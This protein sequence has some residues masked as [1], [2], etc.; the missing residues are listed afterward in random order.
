MRIKV[1]AL[2]I[3]D[4]PSGP[5]AVIAADLQVGRGRTVARARYVLL[6][7]ETRSELANHLAA[8]GHRDYSAAFHTIGGVDDF[9]R[10]VRSHAWTAA[11]ELADGEPI[12]ARAGRWHS[13]ETLWVRADAAAVI[14]ADFAEWRERHPQREGAIWAP[15]WA[16]LLGVQAIA[17]A[18]DQAVPTENGVRTRHDGAKQCDCSL[19]IAADPS[20]A[21]AAERAAARAAGSR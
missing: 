3:L 8:L 10:L 7:F 18:L 13:G 14:L 12:Q 6:P 5:Q 20:R 2:G 9:P 1:H 19:C 16:V 17:L 21:D 4:A 11:G 15:S